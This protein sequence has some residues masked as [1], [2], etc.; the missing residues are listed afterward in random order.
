MIVDRKTYE[1]AMGILIDLN[2][3]VDQAIAQLIVIE[4]LERIK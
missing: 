2:I 3:L 4:Q 1:L